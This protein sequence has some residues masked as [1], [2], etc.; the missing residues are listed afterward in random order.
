MLVVPIMAAA[1]A[2]AAGAPNAQ[3]A[4]D[5]S[6]LDDTCLECAGI[7]I[8]PC[9]W[10]RCK[11]SC[12]LSLKVPTRM[13][14]C[15]NMSACCCSQC[16]GHVVCT[17]EP[18][19]LSCVARAV[20]LHARGD[21]TD[22]CG[23]LGFHVQVTCV[24]GQASGAHSAAR[25]PRT[26]TSLLSAHSATGVALA[27]VAAALVGSLPGVGNGVLCHFAVIQTLLACHPEV[28]LDGGAK[29]WWPA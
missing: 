8:V 14:S 29:Q 23:L 2:A 4:D 22:T 1:G 20:Q 28:K 11:A 26:H 3:A 9:R 27:S 16:I 18:E 17:F 15:C 7:G 21:A 25:E 10:L 19:A 13:A 24:A 12:G 5:L 6:N